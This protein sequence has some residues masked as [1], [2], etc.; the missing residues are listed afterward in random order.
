MSRTE[1]IVAPHFL[2]TLK[3]N[4]W[5]YI[6]KIARYE[7]SHGVYII[8]KTIQVHIV[9]PA[10]KEVYLYREKKLCQ[11]SQAQDNRQLTILKTNDNS[12][13]YNRPNITSEMYPLSLSSGEIFL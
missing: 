12:V 7:G 3:Q 9:P 4:G 1:G 6:Q 10:T 11:R 8:G 2:Y 5:N 13:A